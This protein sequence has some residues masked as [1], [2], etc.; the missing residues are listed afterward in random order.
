MVSHISENFSRDYTFQKIFK[1]DHTFQKIFHVGSHIS[2]NVRAKSHVS[3]N[4]LLLKFLSFR[5]RGF[6]QKHS[7]LDESH[8]SHENNHKTQQT[9]QQKQKQN[10]LY[11]LDGVNIAFSRNHGRLYQSLVNVSKIFL[12]PITRACLPLK[13]LFYG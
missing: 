1:R 13:F 5:N 6:K 10:S 12:S 8:I 2:E 11:I 4:M 9:Q 7:F 3:K